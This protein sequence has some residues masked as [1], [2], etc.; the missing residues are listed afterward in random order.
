MAHSEPDLG[1]N[2]HQNCWPTSPCRWCLL[3]IRIHEALPH[4]HCRLK[5]PGGT[6]CIRWN[7]R[8]ETSPRPWLKTQKLWW[9]GTY[10]ELSACLKPVNEE[11]PLLD[12]FGNCLHVENDKGH[13]LLHLSCQ[14]TFLILVV[15]KPTALA[16]RAAVYILVLPRV[17]R[18]TLQRSTRRLLA[19]QWTRMT[20]K[21]QTCPVKQFR[22]VPTWQDALWAHASKH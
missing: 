7:L 10:G 16:G 22:R 3:C 9:C 17:A 21:S 15:T 2:C 4:R 1:L 13:F 11:L 18:V 19:A 6:L 8:S 12:T 20:H 5:C 14:S